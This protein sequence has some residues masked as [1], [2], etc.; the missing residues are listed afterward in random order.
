MIKF[1]NRKFVK[2]ISGTF[3]VLL[4]LSYIPYKIAIEYE[5]GLTKDLNDNWLSRTRL[6]ES[7]ELPLIEW[8]E[9]SVTSKGFNSFTFLDETCV[10][11]KYLVHTRWPLPISSYY[12]WK[13]RLGGDYFYTNTQVKDPCYLVEQEDSVLHI[14]TSKKKDS[15]VY[16]SAIAPQ[17]QYYALD[18]DYLPIGD[19]YET[20]Q[21]DVRL[22]SLANRLKFVIRY[23]KDVKFDMYI[24]SNSLAVSSDK[25]WKE[26]IKPLTLS[27]GEYSHIRLEVMDDIYSLVVNEERIITV[28]VDNSSDLGN[29]WCLMSWNSQ[30]E[31]PCE[32]KIKNFRILHKR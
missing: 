17:A 12:W 23:N 32:F 15:W 1:L 10:D 30:E 9:D 4:M 5:K 3:I 26:F 21:I 28:K 16:L 8:E 19:Q 18:F 27:K 20:L 11:I 14:K 2:W 25:R 7:N 13:S 24:Q 31:I 6:V 22:R 29:Y